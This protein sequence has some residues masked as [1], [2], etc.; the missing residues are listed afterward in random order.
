MLQSNPSSARAA[1]LTLAAT[2]L[3]NVLVILD[4]TIVN[5]ALERI[6]ASLAT[7][8]TGLQWVVNAYTLVF[9]SLLLTAGALGDRLG[10]KRMFVAGF[11]LFTGASLVCATAAE[12]G[13]LISGRTLQGLGAALC[14]PASLALVNASFPN[15]RDR[16]R[17]LSLWAGAGGIALAAGP[18]VGG[19][20]VD[21]FGW[22]SIFFLNL[23]LGLVGIWLALANAPASRP[24]QRR[25]LD[26]AGQG[27]A[28]AALGSLTL[29]F[30]ES[31]PLGFAHPLV[32][33]SLTFS[34]AA[35]GCFLFVEAR[36]KAPMLPLSLFRAPAVGA[37]CFVALVL[38]FS[39]YGLMFA[40][41]LFFQQGKGYS[42][43]A[44]G[45]AFLPMTALVAIVNL[46]A[47]WMTAHY[48][49]RVPMIIGQG[50]AAL[51][52]AGLA[53]ITLA[54]PYAAVV[55]PLL[56][57]GIGIALSV[58]AMTAAVLA[59]VPHEQ[60]GVASGA[61]NASRQ[62]GGMIGVGVFGSLIAGG[63]DALVGGMHRALILATLAS[64]LGCA[65]S[66]RIR[67]RH[68]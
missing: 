58:P 1:S 11:A 48:G 14:L 49:P 23:P 35:A 28:I 55:L 66:Q 60:A 32:F 41:S 36:S 44:A 68:R 10:A 24:V 46:V 40:L 8:I 7:D 22:P 34:I 53:W 42:P 15:N 3:G 62:T 6:Q 20:L 39:F 26:L 12:V 45:L 37:A 65:A 9:A 31:G 52:Y 4:V 21:R 61:L 47:G 59:S 25:G 16:A 19:I 56:A 57:A 29:G 63:T 30:I 2:C 54:T 67:I 5:V 17:A 64:L 38:N 50:L 43:F 27:L 18:V 13:V 33:G 51:G